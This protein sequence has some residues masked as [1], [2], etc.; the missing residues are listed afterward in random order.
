[1][2]LVERDEELAALE[3]LLADAR[4]GTGSVVLVEGSA[5]I[6]KTTLL[7][8]A[9]ERAADGGMRVLHGR[10]TEL[11]REYPLG[12][13]RQCLEPAIRPDAERERRLRGAARLAGPV[14][15]DVPEELEATPVG[16][17]H[18]LYWLVANLAEEAP[19][20]LVVDDAH[21]A[22]EP[23][24]R[25][26]AYV[27]RRVESLPVALLIAARPA[28][29]ADRGALAAIGDDPAT[30]RIEPPALGLDGVGRLLREHGPVDRAFARACHDA[31]GGNP[32]LLG[33]LVRAL[34]A[35]GVPFTATGAERVTEV[36]PPTVSR[37]VAATL[38][39][40][41]R[42]ATALARAAAVLGDAIALDT[43]A[44]LA[45]VPVEQASAAASELV[46]SGL[47]DDATP[48][49][50]RHPILT[51]AV[52]AGLSTY[53]RAAAHARAADLLRARGAAPERVALQVLHAPP[54]GDASVVSELRLAAEHARER[55][56]PATAAALLA[57]ALAE[58]PE[59]GLLGE[60]LFELGRAELA[61]AR[62]D[63]PEHLAEAHRSA[64]DPAIRGRALVLLAQ[65]IP[66]RR[67]SRVRLFELVADTL[68]D[69]EQRDREVAL[70]LR[71][72]LALQGDTD[73]TAAPAGDTLGEAV[74]LGHLLLGRMHPDAT[75]AEIAGLA[76]RAARQVD[77]LLEDGAASL[78]F[79]GMILGLRW[80][81]R[82]EEAER[83]LDRAIAA[84]RRRGSTIDFASAMTL[85]AAVRRRAGHLGDAEA[86]A[87]VALAAALGPEWSFARG[88]VPLVGSL[89]DQGRLEE[90]AR[91]LGDVLDGEEIADSPPM[92]PVL[93]ARMRVRAAGGEHTAALA[94]WDE[95]VR[96]VESVGR[97]VNAGWIEDL[98][99]VAGIHLARRDRSAAE[100]V[101]AQ[102]VELATRWGTP[103]A[104][105]QALHTQAR[106]SSTN[107][108]LDV[109]RSA[110]DLLER[111]PVRLEHARACVTLGG[112]LR[113]RG[114]RA[115]SRVQLR[116]GYELAHRCGADAL[117][118]SA[119]AELRASGIRLQREP[120]SGADSLT[121]S[122]RRIAEM[123]AE[124]LS[125]AEIAQ[126]LFL[127]VKTIEMH[128]T[129]AYRKLD[130][131]RRAQ[132]AQALGAKS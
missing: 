113:R 126:E 63:A 77:G 96:R 32:F 84:A 117:A 2:A 49:R 69:V 5:G 70:R 104:I 44:E 75:A 30:T 41:G 93:L 40:L 102:G 91:E 47:L 114:H 130:V 74:F 106:I 65:A 122:E 36:T 34:R 66:V 37:A 3:R 120:V 123:A 14:L 7:A 67:E 80:T 55:G 94:D 71:A 58:P 107:A 83:L 26:L 101:A 39:R 1:M 87:R 17:L 29:E 48:M 45:E 99:V 105:G 64:D 127:T 81:D 51:A 125:N 115:E 27:A 8:A 28:E 24:L 11:E 89:L 57:R 100:A 116:E 109:L 46:R 38:A 112:A 95:A 22:D 76:T 42:E 13:A 97:G 103:G 119:R 15:L 23:S 31:T 73:L 56:A 4:S 131:R 16:I 9:R 90:A 43:A 86:D 78:A 62:P 88:V 111:S 61:T 124:G 85:R 129:R 82:L 54:A 79:T 6:G 132:L 52:R 50:F 92:I 72:V 18:G 19:V 98:V 60:V 68:P 10:G 53:D 35:D 25:F 121:P 128:L 20:L 118:E 108:S 110:V 33:E 12:V 21:W 59:P